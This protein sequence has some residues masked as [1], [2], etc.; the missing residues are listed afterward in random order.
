MTGRSNACA[1]CCWRKAALSGGLAQ[2]RT[3]RDP[4]LKGIVSLYKDMSIL[5]TCACFQVLAK[6]CKMIPVMVMGTLVGGIHY[7]SLE[8]VCA[9]ML[10]AGI[11]LFAHQSSSAVKQ[12][13]ASPNA[14]L[15]YFLCLVNLVFDGYTNAAQVL[16]HHPHFLRG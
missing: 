10:A 8:Y 13:L 11:S 9:L 12:K 7:S 5:L 6:S 1:S 14:P 3:T 2:F 15:G 16:A 4:A